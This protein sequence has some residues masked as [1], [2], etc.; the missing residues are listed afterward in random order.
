MCKGMIMTGHIIY[1]RSGQNGKH[2]GCKG[3]GKAGRMSGI[4]EFPVERASGCARRWRPACDARNPG[5]DGVAG[6]VM[7]GLVPTGVSSQGRME[8]TGSREKGK[9]RNRSQ[10]LGGSY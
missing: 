2:Q 6:R 3:K 9:S 5:C 4:E 8:H 7:T 1:L 10:G